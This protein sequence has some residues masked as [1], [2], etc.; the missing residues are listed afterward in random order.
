MHASRKLKQ[1]NLGSQRIEHINHSH[2]VLKDVICP[3]R[4]QPFYYAGMTYSLAYMRAVLPY[5]N[6]NISHQPD[7]ICI[8]SY[9]CGFRQRNEEHVKI[10]QINTPYIVLVAVVCPS[11]QQ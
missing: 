3:T 4:Q 10:Q 2:L 9:I 6:T 7:C 11:S 8:T 1:T 5:C